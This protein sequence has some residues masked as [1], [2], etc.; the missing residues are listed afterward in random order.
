MLNEYKINGYHIENVKEYAENSF[1]T[2]KKY[3]DFKDRETEFKVLKQ[4]H[5]HKQKLVGN[6]RIPGSPTWGDWC[7]SDLTYAGIC[8]G[9]LC[10]LPLDIGTIL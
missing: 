9:S 5:M 7:E 1:K 2:W 8:S 10:W 3:V 4:F 6:L